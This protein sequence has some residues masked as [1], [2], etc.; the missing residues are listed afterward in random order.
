MGSDFPIVSLGSP[1][2]IVLCGVVITIPDKLDRWNSSD[3][4]SGLCYPTSDGVSAHF[5]TCG[6]FT[7]AI[8]LD[9]RWC[10][11]FVCK[12]N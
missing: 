8:Y 9:S 5:M 6:A 11:G 12:S 10:A 3:G 7:M 1:L 2:I 4:A